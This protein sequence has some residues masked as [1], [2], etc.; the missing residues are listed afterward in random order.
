MFKAT[1]NKGVQFT[2]ANGHTVSVQWGPGNYCEG[3]GLNGGTDYLAPT[4]KE[5]W[6]N[7]K[8]EIAT[9]DRDGNWNLKELWKAFTGTEELCDEVKGYMSVDDV[10][11]FLNFV[12][13]L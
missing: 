5:S 6:S 9:W 7:P 13:S 8:A 12:R 4:K 2:F 11:E 3:Y 1:G 10:V